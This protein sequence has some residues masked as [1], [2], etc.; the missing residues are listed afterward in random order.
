MFSGNYAATIW[1]NLLIVMQVPDKG[2]I[3][4][5]I[6]RVWT[7]GKHL[8]KLGSISTEARTPKCRVNANVWTLE[9]MAAG[10]AFGPACSERT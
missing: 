8:R 9:T 10:L 7:L 6:Q 5:S 1:C 2:L 3:F 4:T